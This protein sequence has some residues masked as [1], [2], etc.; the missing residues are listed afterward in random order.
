MHTDEPD[1]DAGPVERLIVARFPRWA[2]LP[3]HPVTSAVIVNA[4]QLPGGPACP[5]SPPIRRTA[6]AKATYSA[7]PA[8]SA[9]FAT[10]RCRATIT[11]R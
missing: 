8:R 3:I 10:C 11:R 1:I 6:F 2:D 4:L 5:A 7:A 9:H